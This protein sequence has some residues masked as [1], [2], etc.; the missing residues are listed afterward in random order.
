M[1]ACEQQPCEQQ[2]EASEPLYAGDRWTFVAVLPDRYQDSGRT[3]PT[4]YLEM[5]PH[6]TPAFLSDAQGSSRLCVSQL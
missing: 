2:S 5:E 6:R 1:P 4:L 3:L